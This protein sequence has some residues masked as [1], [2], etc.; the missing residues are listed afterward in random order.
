MIAL[1]SFALADGWVS[2]FVGTVFGGATG[3]SLSE[4]TRDSSSLTYGFNAGGM[5]GGIFGAE[6]D[7]G[8]TPKF[9]GTGDL[10]SASGVMTVQGSLIVGI[11]VGGQS[12]AGVRP[13]GLFGVGLIRRRIEFSGALENISKNDWGYNLGGGIMGFFTDLLGA[14]VEYRYFRN[15]SSDDGSLNIFKPGTF[16]FSRFSGG[17]VLRF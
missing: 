2:G 15:F 6:F 1:P 10:V 12:G 3:Q 9:F 17:I 7:F 16:N 11:P 13:Y 14:R 5:S 8:Y 4:S